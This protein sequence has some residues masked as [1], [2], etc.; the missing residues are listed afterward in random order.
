[1]KTS[2]P[3]VILALF[4]VLLAVPVAAQNTATNPLA[5]GDWWRSRHE[6]FKRRAQQ[7]G[8]DILFLGD[9]ITEG[10][11]RAGSNVWNRHFAP[12]RAAAFGISGDRTQHLLWRLQHGELDGLQPKVVVLLIGTN[13]TGKERDSDVPRNTT[14]EAIA[15]VTAVVHTLREKLPHSRVLLLALFPRGDPDDPQRAQV[16]EVNRGL[17][18]LHDGKGVHFLDLGRHFVG[19]DG[20]ISPEIMPDKLHLSEKGYELWAEHLHEPLRRLLP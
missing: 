16:A 12:Q 2:P 8:V 13:N 11:R 20:V 19:A 15:G 5:G 17:A 9:S 6:S 1:M 3:K 7:G 18:Q 4:A 14:E 10:W